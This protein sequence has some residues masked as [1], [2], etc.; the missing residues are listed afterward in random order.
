M[1]RTGTWFLTAIFLSAAF[2]GCLTGD[3]ESEQ[4]AQE[5]AKK[6][7]AN[8]K[9]N[10]TVYQGL[11]D[12]TGS[13]SYTLAKGPYAFSAKTP[14]ELGMKVEI[15]STVTVGSQT[16]NPWAVNNPNGMISMGVWLPEVPE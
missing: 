4:E 6:I 1:N 5:E 15:P 7:A 2:A 8:P 13:Y 3:P 9:F 14:L 16:S 11:Y 12:F 10:N